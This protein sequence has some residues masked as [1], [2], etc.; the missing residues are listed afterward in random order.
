LITNAIFYFFV[1]VVGTAGEMCVSRATKMIGEVTEFTP[2]AIGRHIWRALKQPWMWI[3]VFMMAIAF[4]SLLG[5]LATTKASFVYP[6][7]ALS[8]GVGALGGK[9]FLKERVTAL[10]WLGV[11]VIC[12]GVILVII[13]KG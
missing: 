9:F 8:Y 6:S 7:T 10:R 12:M 1:V 5:M 3:A 13:G 4:F 11:A 2:R